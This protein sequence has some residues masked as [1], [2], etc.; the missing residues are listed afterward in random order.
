MHCTKTNK[1][2]IYLTMKL[3]FRTKLFLPLAISWVCLLS[4]MT[5]NVMQNKTLRLEERKVQLSN[6]ADMAQS[7]AKEYGAQA[8]SG[9]M[10]EAEAKKQALSR[11]KALRYGKSGYLTVLDSRTCL[12]YTS[13]A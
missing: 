10:P 5:L 13:D 7:V 4:V 8:A 12:L 3:T 2:P 6:A 1:L 9:A 11:I